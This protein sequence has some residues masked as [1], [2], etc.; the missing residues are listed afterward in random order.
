MSGKTDKRRLSAAEVLSGGEMVKPASMRD[1]VAMESAMV[2]PEVTSLPT[3][4]E[5]MAALMGRAS[6]AD[7]ANKTNGADKA[8]GTTGADTGT[9]SVDDSEVVDAHAE[10][11]RGLYDALRADGCSLP[12][13][14]EFRTWMGEEANRRKLYDALRADGCSLPYDY[15]EFAKAI[16][17][18]P[19][20]DGMR[21][22][23]A[24]GEEAM[25]DILALGRHNI[26]SAMELDRRRGV[27]PVDVAEPVSGGV[28]VNPST[29][30]PEQKYLTGSGAVY[31]KGDATLAAQS[32]WAGRERAA[33]QQSVYDEVDATMIDWDAKNPK[34]SKEERNAMMKQVYDRTVWRRRMDEIDREIAGAERQR[35]AIADQ[36]RV[37]WRESPGAQ[38]REIMMREGREAAD[39]Y[40]QSVMADGLDAANAKEDALVRRSADLSQR[41]NLANIR[42]RALRDAKERY[43][44]GEE[45]RESAAPWGTPMGI[46]QDAKDYTMGFAHGV[47]NVV[48]NPLGMVG[49]FDALATANILDKLERREDL[50][51]DE[52]ALLD[53]TVFGRSTDAFSG[54]KGIAYQVGEFVPE[55]AEMAAEFGFSPMSGATRAVCAQGIKRLGIHGFKQ[56]LRHPKFMAKVAGT[57]TLEG[58]SIAATT[59]AAK[60]YTEMVG[61]MVGDPVRDSEGKIRWISGGDSMGEAF[62]KTAVR[63]VGSNAVFVLPTNVGGSL[64]KA[65]ESGEV[66]KIIT[67]LARSTKYLPWHNPVDALVKMKTS[68][69][70]YVA[71]GDETWDD[72]TDKE[73]N[74][75]LLGSVLAAEMTSNGPRAAKAAAQYGS[76]KYFERRMKG[77]YFRARSLFEQRGGEKAGEAWDRLTDRLTTLDTESAVNL[78]TALKMMSEGKRAVDGEAEAL[79][80]GTTVTTDEAAAFFDFVRAMVGYQSQYCRRRAGGY[81]WTFEDS[82]SYNTGGFERDKPQRRI[83]ETATRSFDEGF[84]APPSDLDV[85]RRAAAEARQRVVD[86]YGEEYASMID[87]DPIGFLESRPEDDMSLEM[88]YINLKARQSGIE[89]RISTT[90]SEAVDAANAEECRRINRQSGMVVR[91]R[92]GAD[93]ETAREAYVVSGNVS[94][95]ADGLPDR[96]A[97]DGMLVVMDAESG[98]L[99]YCSPDRLFSVEEMRAP[100]LELSEESPEL[101]EAADGEVEADVVDKADVTNEANVSDGGMPSEAHGFKINDTTE[102]GVLGSDELQSGMVIDVMSD[103]R[104]VVWTSQPVDESSVELAEGDGLVGYA[105]EM[106]PRQQDNVAE[107]DMSEAVSGAESAGGGVEGDM[108]GRSLSPRESTDLIARMESGAEVAPEVELTPENWISQFG[109][110]GTVE[111][112]LGTVKMGDNQYFKL[113]QQGRD[114]KLGMVKPTL[115]RPD[116][117]IEDYRPAAN[118]ERDTSFIFVKTFNKS[119]GSR[120]YY[121]TSVTVSKGGREVV[122]SNQEKSGKRISKLLQQGKVAWIN[123]SSL[124]PNTQVGKPVSLNDSNTPTNSDNEG[125]L[126][127]IDS[128]ADGKVREN[129]GDMQAGDSALSRIAVDKD[130]KPMYESAP[131]DVAW[132]AIVERAGGD[133]AIAGEVAA[134]MVASARE[135]LSAAEQALKEIRD[136]GG[137]NKTAGRGGRKGDKASAQRPMDADDLIAAKLDARAKEAE[138]MQAVDA[139]RERLAKWEEI[140]S[141]ASSREVAARAEV[142]KAEREEAEARAREEARLRAED[143]VRQQREREELEGVPDFSI[144]KPEDA[145]RRGFVRVAGAKIERQQPLPAGHPGYGREVEPMF[146]SGSKPVRA[147]GRV[148]ITEVDEYQP[149]H[150]DG[151]INPAHMIPEAQPKA[152]HKDGGV[153]LNTAEQNAKNIDPRLVTR[154]EDPYTGAPVVN[155]HREGVQGNGRLQMLRLLYDKFPEKGEVYKQYLIDHA[156]AFGV[157]PDYIRSLKRPAMAI[158][159]EGDDARAIELGQM[160]SQDNESGGIERI[161]PKHTARKMG[162]DMGKFA[163]MLMNDPG[164]GEASFA[165]LVTQNGAQTLDWM[166][167]N[168]YISDTQ[169][170]SALRADGRLTEDA[171]KDLKDILY[172]NIFDGAPTR[173]EEMFAALPAKAQKAILATAYRDHS[174]PESE[175]LVPEIQDAITASYMLRSY[176]LFAEAKNPEACRRAIESWKAQSTIDDLGNVV[177]PAEI[178]SNFALELAARFKGDTQKQIQTLL[179]RILDAVQGRTEDLFAEGPVKPKTVAEAIKEVTGIDYNPKKSKRNGKD[180]DDRDALLDRGDQNGEVGRPA[181]GG[182]LARGE[183]DQAGAG[184]SERGRGADGV[185]PEPGVRSSEQSE[186]SESA[187][188]DVDKADK[189]DVVNGGEPTAAQKEAGNYKKEHRRIDGYR[190]SIENAKGSVRRGTDASGDSWEVTMQND[191]GYIRGTEGVDGDHIDVFLSDTPEVGDVFV[192]DQVK[193]DGTF[194]EHKVMYGFG[195]EAEARQAYLSNYSPGWRGLGAITRV[196]KEEFKKWVNSSKRKTKPFADYHTI[197]K[198]VLANSQGS[199][200]EN[201][202]IRTES[203]EQSEPS[204]G[205]KAGGEMPVTDVTDTNQQVKSVPKLYDRSIPTTREEQRNAITRII[206]FAKKVKDRVERAVIGGI[207]K[208]QKDDFAKF[209]IDIDDSWVHSFETS[210]VSHN[211]KHHGNPTVEAARGQIA[212]TAEDYNR[213]PDILDHYDK[214]SKSPNKTKGTE[215]DVIIYEK[216]FDDGYVFYLEEKRDN[217]KSLAFHTMYKKKKGTDSSDGFAVNSTAPITPKATPDNLDSISEGKGSGLFDDLQ[218]GDGEKPSVIE[219][220]G[221]KIAG[222]RKDMLHDLAKSVENVT[223]QSLIELPLGKAFKKPNLKKMSESGAISDSDAMLAEAVMQA[224]IFGRKKPAA[225]RRMNSK[226]EISE[227]A[228]S[229]YDGIRFLGEI[230]SGDV[231]RRDKALAD[232]RAM[233]ADRLAKANAHIENLRQWNPDKQ[234]E[235]HESLPDEVEVIRNVLERIGYRAGD[236]VSLPLCRISISSNGKSYEVQSAGKQGAFWFKRHH[237]TLESAIKTMELAARLKRG[238]MEAELTA[239]DFIVSGQGNQRMESSGQYEVLYFTK[240]NQ[241]ASKIFDNEADASAFAQSNGGRVREMKRC[242]N[243][244]DGYQATVVNPLTG[245]RHPIGEV[246]P[247]RGDVSAWLD[248]NHEEANRQGLEAIYAEIGTKRSSREHF[249]IGTS[250]DRDA[251]KVVYSVIEDDKSNPWPIKKEFSSRNE[252]E[253]WLK[254]NMSR[255]EEERKIRKEKERQMVYFNP[256]GDRRGPDHRQGNAAT[257]EMFA[258]TFGFRG[259]Q[260]GNWTSGADRQAAL[261]QAYDALMDMAGVLGLTPRAM[262]L[263]GELGLAFGARGGGAASA[264]YEPGAVVINL[265][266]TKGAGALAHEWWHA[267][268]NYLARHGGVPLGH[269]TDG[270]GLDQLRPE[271]RAAIGAYMQAVDGSEYARRSRDKGDYWGRSTEVGARLFESWIDYK[272]NGA[273]EHSPFLASGL[274]PDV[275]SLYRRLNYMA[276]RGQERA[277]AESRGVAPQVMSEEE[278]NSRPES[279]RGYPYP[280]KSELESFDGA[281]S[282]V[283][284]ALADRESQTGSMAQERRGRYRR[285]AVGRSL[286]DAVE[287]SERSKE[288]A[289]AEQA[290]NAIDAFAASYSEYL[291]RSEELENMKA[292][293]DR[294]DRMAELQEQMEREDALISEHRALLEESLRDFYVRNNTPEDAAE[295]AR[296]MVARA[297]AEVEVRRNGRQILR[298]IAGGSGQSESSARLEAEQTEAAGGQVKTAGGVISYNALGHLPDPANGE[299]G[300]VERQMSLIGEF[301]FTG[302]SSV[303]DRGDVAYIF[304]ALEDYSIEHVFVAFQKGESLKV[305]HIGMGGPTQSFADLGAIRAGYDAFGADKIYLIHNHPTGKLLASVPDQKLM[306]T[307]EAAFPDIDTEGIIMDTTSGR[308]GTF[309]GMGATESHERPQAGGDSEVGVMRIDRAKRDK[310]RLPEMPVIRS[311]ADVASYVGGQ[312]LGGGDKVSFLVLANDNR[313]VANFH[314]GY[315]SLGDPGLADE[316]ASVATKWGGTSVI[317]YGNVD[318]RGASALKSAVTSK[319]LGGVRL[320]DAMEITNGLNRSAMDEGYLREGRPAAYGEGEV[321]EPAMSRGLMDFEATR[322]RALAER[323][324]VMPG[325]NKAKVR[326]VDVPR[327]DF[328]GDRPIAQAKAWAKANLIGEHYLTDSDGREVEYSISNRTISK[329]FSESAIDNSENLGV[330]LSVLKK[331]P[332]VIS[333]SVEAEVHPDYHKG[334][335][336]KRA[337]ENGHGEDKLIHRFYGAVTIDGEAYRVKTTIAETRE[338]KLPIT[339][340]SFEVTEIELLTDANSPKSLEPTVSPK[341]SGVPHRIAKLLNG[342]EKS[343]DPGVQ[344]LDASEKSVNHGYYD[345]YEGEG[346]G[347]VREPAMSTGSADF[348]ATRERALAERGL[349]MPGLNKAKVRVVDV[350]RH[351]FSGDRPIAQAKAWA[352]ANLIGEHYLTDSKGREVEYSISGKS[353]EKYL[354]ESAISKSDDIG[355]HL[356]ALKKLPEIIGESV[357]CE[358]HPS[359]NKIDGHRLS[360]NGYNNDLL[361]HRFYGAIAHEGNVYRVKTTL[362]EHLDAKTSP[363]PH[364]YEVAKIEV[365]PDYSGNTSIGGAQAYTPTKRGTLQTTKI[366]KGVEKSYDPGVKLLDA[367]RKEDVRAM[368]GEHGDPLKDRVLKAALYMAGK[369][370]DNIAARDAAVKA[371]GKRVGNIRKAMRAQK[372]YDASTVGEIRTVADAMLESGLLDEMSGGEVKRLLGAMAVSVEKGNL[373]VATDRLLDLV[374]DNQ[375]RLSKDMLDKALRVKGSK[376]NAAGVRVGAKLDPM[377][378]QMVKAAREG[379]EALTEDGVAERIQYL[380]NEIGEATKAK[381]DD[382]KAEYQAMLT[383]MEIARGYHADVKA[384][385][386]AISDLNFE[387]TKL[388]RTW[389]DLETKEERDCYRQEKRALEEAIRTLKSEKADGLREVAGAIMGGVGESM[390]RMKAWREAEQARIDHIHHMANADMEG[391]P[392]SAHER[393]KLKGMGRL[394]ERTLNSSLGEFLLGPTATFEQMMRLFASHSIDGRGYVYERFIPG[395]ME[396]N[397]RRWK[398]QRAQEERLNAK[399]KEVAGVKRWSGLYEI[400]KQPAGTI[401]WRDGGEMKEFVI[402]QDNLM[403]VYMANKMEDGIMKLRG[404]GISEE[405]MEEVVKRLDPRLKKLADWV[406]E[407]FLPSNKGRYNDVHKRMFNAPMAE[408]ENYF[409]LKVLADARQQ[410]MEIKAD[411]TGSTALPRTVTGAIIERT[412]NNL[413]LDILRSSAISIVLDNLRDMEEWAAFAEYRRDVG[414]LLSYTRFRN[415]VKNTK[416]IYG[417]G[418]NLWNKMVKLALITCG[419]YER[420]QSDLDK[421]AVNL[422]KGVTG[423]CIAFRLNTALKQ[424]LS[425][426]AFASEA[427]AIRMMAALRHPIKSWRWSMEN[428]PSLQERWISRQAGN[429][430]LKVCKDDWSIYDK[431]WIKAIG[432]A[433]ISPNAFIDAVTV[434]I[435]S[436]AV[437]ESKY[438]EYV[439][440]GWSAEVSRKKAILDAEIAFNLSQQSSLA[441]FMSIMQSDRTLGSTMLTIF[442]NSPMSYLRQQV[443]ATREINNY[444][445]DHGQMDYEVKKLQRE[446][447]PEEKAKAYANKKR[448]RVIAKNLFRLLNFG[449]ILPGLWA[450]GGAMWYLMAGDDKEQKQEILEDAAIRGLYGTL[451]GVTLGGMIPDMIFNYF[452]KDEPSRL[453]DTSLLPFEQEAS[454]AVDALTGNNPWKGVHKTINLLSQMFSGGNPQLVEDWVVAGMDFFG[455]DEKNGE[456]W[457]LLGM[458]IFQVPQSQLD[459]IYLDK[460][461]LWSDEARK[462]PPAKLARRWAHYKATRSN[463]TGA[464]AMSA[465]KWAEEEE[466]QRKRFNKM[467]KELLEGADKSG[468]R[469]KFEAYNDEYMRIDAEYKDLM[470]KRK[471]GDVD[472]SAIYD[473]L[474]ELKST[475]EYKRYERFAKLKGA[476]DS[477]VDRWLD[478]ATPEATLEALEYHETTKRLLVEIMDNKN[479][480][481]VMEAAAE[482]ADMERRQKRRDLG[483]DD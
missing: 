214:I 239:R 316:L 64:L 210:A 306:S 250:Y 289:A 200:A 411:A 3:S 429:E 181:G 217:R 372:E 293:S 267:L 476:Y 202:N 365:L 377:G 248:S 457:A 149:S 333:E 120:F 357:E 428:L 478:A 171:V 382:L 450:M 188:G 317:V 237:D 439:K 211:Q 361:V 263:D 301:G 436:K 348:E 198:E 375:V 453:R 196:S 22:A 233:M 403:Y 11:M 2:M 483:W 68:E 112:P 285:M 195:S 464:L 73:A 481:S 187:G 278:F 291:E 284:S 352:K 60:N 318:V 240:R 180:V 10:P 165:E 18:Q 345:S 159:I 338:N 92:V 201:K 437:Y 143:E 244:Y 87:S 51:E 66:G 322:E 38:Y 295:I 448:K 271:V 107:A 472:R 81:S 125:A 82:T 340:H 399:A 241:V 452:H 308:Y 228:Q 319:S 209:G 20:I 65:M 151:R 114:G 270:H 1:I 213:I 247:T 275:E 349:V 96:S 85:T 412:K 8:N 183:H 303:K 387:L 353:I 378:Q 469:E 153:S 400:G 178:F 7:K 251:G 296:Q 221:E 9:R 57:A 467:A 23:V 67:K 238:D 456:E 110:D 168:G 118:S 207:T 102:V 4:G 90:E 427:N 397:D 268:D 86:Q 31:G 160:T 249:Y 409:P 218:E 385:D 305:M 358:I 177:F 408:V 461:G 154:T 363:H 36:L 75:V 384:K 416:S 199:V 130:G 223:V 232:R 356:S 219:D 309:H 438:N 17:Y 208:R 402:T 179:V 182:T 431:K 126:L 459:M 376:T 45:H 300:L 37:A 355:I 94:V 56:L 5:E 123:N 227:W 256:S 190:I 145:R 100:R 176:G 39:A 347:E 189:S 328:S 84:D 122:I 43:E 212:I 465:E 424:L 155:R 50:T 216:E 462:E 220:F 146:A 34:A 283:L 351:D 225:S 413:P 105:T 24:R 276:Y 91:V 55:I 79:M 442:R 339:P 360:D 346:I 473:R 215:N 106:V 326:V 290:N 334:E 93:E 272:L 25:G 367:S 243:E 69:L 29:G 115:Q 15:N 394:I 471:R 364:A 78:A 423:A 401:S 422:A 13:Y 302:N 139:A 354:S 426:P 108:I 185:R 170:S 124:H 121:F 229:T 435:G 482:L 167:R 419:A 111:T 335:D 288:S 330:H 74:A 466:K 174:S 230:L 169:K 332:E 71:L 113:A 83:A 99:E 262:S 418:D 235:Y 264:H 280:T 186:G 127:G 433:G 158:E 281:V 147:K 380:Y 142:E 132:D 430:L 369:D 342:V 274:N 135:A 12:E 432:R 44:R 164:D 445:R 311:S 292:E 470:S 443:Q 193:P 407:E 26:E 80:R 286:F 109:E 222:A 98:K 161:R 343:Y 253:A 138:A 49:A 32:D 152:R 191:Y 166:N 370:E 336:G 116:I 474:R 134:E 279:L 273:G 136:G 231:S 313:I 157:D 398:N 331:L 52:E 468:Y 141:V 341:E 371:I 479:L 420:K 148:L 381:N 395:W 266:K 21:S 374:I 14:G 451:D 42:L 299:F 224:L 392:I 131:S 27:D 390:E 379:I 156:E 259:V 46:W 329:Y 344:L 70:F 261:D 54:S 89:A 359:Y 327:H 128:S 446:G 197:K 204:E 307:L 97:S 406:Q 324:L 287:E 62:A 417:S 104:L 425:L 373:R 48:T 242:T 282:G 117:I 297:Q 323:G 184:T 460:L 236:A 30:L 47:K 6:G 260:F 133:T 421:A 194:D 137:A 404:M 325:L 72:Y 447:L 388:L 440:A 254:D 441:P 434:A 58:A 444:I 265:T 386:R 226:R 415:Q 396:C 175:R 480:D 41:L 28:G 298:D 458:R 245:N 337:P 362:I 205:S 255:L 294:G 391:T 59:Q 33:E 389:S 252:A 320:L 366:L 455:A 35:D 383:G 454:G 119:D 410:D 53:A 63:A 19:N 463:I 206:D 304:R 393:P 129:A 162:D 144:D 258:D 76:T 414:T 192:V 405:V 95:T 103:G 163:A 321:R 203:S 312:R 449:F 140:A 61:R 88:E 477:S 150:V 246:M 234:F 40:M 314:T 101:S 350:P 315:G 310:D 277:R 173:M 269:V 172:Q 16:S 77:A 368:I 257:P 475:D